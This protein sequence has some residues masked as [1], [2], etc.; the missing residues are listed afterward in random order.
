M[1]IKPSTLGLVIA[2][3]LLGGVAV[4]V[5][6][7]PAPESSES[8]QASSTQQEQRIFE[9]EE[10]DVQT[11]SLKTRLRSLKFERD[12]DDKWQMQEPDK[13][14]AS[15][16]S[17]AFLLDLVA[18]GKTQESLT[19]PASDREQFGL[20]QPLATI[21]VTLKDKKTHKLVV[22]DYNFNRSALY[23]QADPP[24]DDK[25]DLKLLLVSPNFDNAVNR[26][27]AEWKQPATAEKSPSPSSSAS[28]SPTE[29]PT[30]SA[31]P[32]AAPSNSPEPENSPSPAN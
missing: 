31:S 26:P 29:S 21:E 28:P 22:G 15:D 8:S 6:Q 16:P 27:L 12:K 32:E 30:P 4:I 1:K 19:A 17:I 3:L 20:H 24:A 25:A 18:S 5:A 2:A 7:Q 14:A 23:A 10:K 9:F 13:T 11:I